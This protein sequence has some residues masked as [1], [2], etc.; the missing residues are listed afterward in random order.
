MD[1]ALKNLDQNL[2]S[3]AT[4]PDRRNS[5]FFLFLFLVFLIFCF[6]IYSLTLIREIRNL[7]KEATN[8]G[9]GEFVADEYG[10]PVFRFKKK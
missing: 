7:H 4:I 1:E 5:V 2:E 6:F 3:N 10:Q 9:V 8:I